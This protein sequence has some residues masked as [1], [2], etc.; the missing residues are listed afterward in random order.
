MDDTTTATTSVP[1]PP[2]TIAANRHRRLWWALP[3]L[4]I[5][6]LVLGSVVAASLVR[7][8]LWEVAPGTAEDVSS[9]LEFDDEARS[10]VTRHPAENPLLFVTAYGNKLSA[11]DALAGAI[12]EDVDVQTFEERFGGITPSE[13]RRLGYQSMTTSKQIA[14]F[15]AFNRLGLDVEII[16][17]DVIVEELVCEETPRKLSACNVLDPG[18]TLVSF[19]GIQIDSLERL[20]TAL[21]AFRPGDV[22]TLQIIPHTKSN[23]EQR[24]VELIQSPDDPERTIIG[25]IPADTRTVKLPFEVDIDTD[26]IGGPSAGL[27]FTLALLDELTPGSLTGDVKVA[28][29][30]TISEDETVGAIGALRQKAVAA[31][32]AGA[33][34]FL[35]PATQS[36]EE[37][38]AARAVA[39]SEMTIIT[40]AN[41][42]EALAAL[43]KLGGSGLTNAAIDL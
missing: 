37:L 3:L 7:L 25:F 8:T 22:V 19:N 16:F 35:V 13:Q 28:V 29:T 23:V 42:E 24:Q 34:V 27:A 43:E 4:T 6:W 10:Q 17:G 9:R 40:V 38:A 26:S 31:K 14:E 30:G 36:P 11:L 33:E 5:A 12:D 15:V 20:S 41:L 21:G 18:D 2:P 1:L 39:G 32:R